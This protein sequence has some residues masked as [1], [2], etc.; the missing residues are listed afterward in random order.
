MEPLHL[1]DKTFHSRL[2][3]GTGKFGSPQLMREALI[4]S[5][6]ELVTVALKRIDIQTEVDATLQA[7]Q[8]PNW[9][10]L[11][12]TSGARNATEA[13]LAAQLAREALE[14]NWLKLEIHPDPKYLLPDPIETLK[15]TEALAKL[16][17]VVLPYIH[18]DPVLCKRL[19]EVGT[20]AVMPLGAPI[21]TNKGLRTQ[22]FL[23]II[24]ES[25]KV[26][27]IVDAGIGAPS[28]A[29]KAMEL[30]ADA[31][32]VNTAIAVAQHPNEMAKAFALAVK[33][34]RMAFEAKLAPI[35]DKAHASSPLTSF[36]FD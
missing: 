20:A 30:G 11:P 18:A 31:I 15:A 8:H 27:V 7:L 34:G 32:L 6:T 33:A 14:T 22:D 3:L 23:E 5:E 24:I 29:A 25:S 36:L 26:P 10:L 1:H 28:D 17:F 13:I 16:G 19:E 2:F 21:G 9:S 12:N 4:H 35:Q